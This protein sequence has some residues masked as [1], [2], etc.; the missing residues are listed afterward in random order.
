MVATASLTLHAQGTAPT[1]R[2]LQ[3][4]TLTVPSHVDS[5]VPMVWTRIDGVQRLVAFASWG[6]IPHRLEGPD[7]EHLQP[8]GMVLMAP[9]AEGGVWFES[10]IADEAGDTW[11]AFYHRELPAHVC[12]RPDRALAS[13]GAARSSDRGF[14]WDNLGIVIDV[15]A[16]SAGCLSANKFVIGGV[17]DASALVDRDWKDIYVYFGMYSRDPRSQGIG[18]ARLAW[19]DRDAPEG[20]A[21]IWNNGAWLHPV[22][23]EETGEWRFPAGTALVTPSRPWHDN[24]NIVDA[25]WGPSIHWNTYLARYVMLLNR[26]KDE[27]YNNEGIYVS[28]AAA[29][30]N[31]AAWSAPQKILNGGG[32]YPLIAGSEPGA[33]TDKQMGQRARFF[34]TGRSTSFI[35]FR[36]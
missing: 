1:V 3:S 30:D 11:Y 12:G 34:L 20:Q 8:T 23:D 35:E 22:Q 13:I 21:A 28:Y 4:S 14:T 9:A 18:I 29:L 6:G 24:N 19:A 25:F 31:P 27:Q 15:P 16:G 26:A 7:L 33:G 5:G 17:G 10:V 2:F 36:K 32:W